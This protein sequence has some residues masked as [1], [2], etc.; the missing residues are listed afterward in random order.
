MKKVPILKPYLKKELKNIAQLTH[1]REYK[2]N[3]FIFKKHAPAEGMYVILE[4]EI[5]IKDPEIR[6]NLFA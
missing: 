4:G 2:L 1:E 6:E 5:E 3:E